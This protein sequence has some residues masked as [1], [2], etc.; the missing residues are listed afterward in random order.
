MST[1]F[2]T[3][4]TLNRFS[5]ENLNGSKTACLLQKNCYGVSARSNK[6]LEKSFTTNKEES[7]A[8]TPDFLTEQA[9]EH[10]KNRCT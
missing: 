9:K 7:I 2:T 8:R 1:R 5:S 10:L 4:L 3:S 6:H